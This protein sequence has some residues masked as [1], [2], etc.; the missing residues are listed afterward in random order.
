MST[1]TLDDLIETIHKCLGAGEGE[2]VTARSADHAFADLG[3][4]SLA[5]YELMTRLQDDT[6]IEISDDDI[7][8]I[9]TPRQALDFVNSRLKQ[10]S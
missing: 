9:E 6:G 1:F 5:V 8:T 7:E 4:D 2:A 3:Y 10:A